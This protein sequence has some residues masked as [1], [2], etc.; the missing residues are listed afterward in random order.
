MP[1]SGSSTKRPISS[2]WASTGI[3]AP[4]SGS[5]KRAPWAE[6]PY[7]ITGCGATAP[8]RLM[9]VVHAV[10]VR[11]RLEP[12]RPE[13][14]E[15]AELVL[16]DGDHVGHLVGRRGR[17]GDTVDAPDVGVGR[18]DPPPCELATDSIVPTMTAATSSA[19]AVSRSLR[20]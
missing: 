12:A 19:I 13:V 8:L 5:S 3:S 9:R 6:R 20:D 16:G 15:A 11:R 14:E 17:L 7:R 2:P 1:S 4:P 10:G 18:T